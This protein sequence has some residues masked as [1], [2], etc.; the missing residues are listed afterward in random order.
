MSSQ[1]RKAD[2]PV[3]KVSKLNPQCRVKLGRVLVQVVNIT[4]KTRF[5]KFRGR[6]SRNTKKPRG[7]RRCLP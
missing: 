3:L 2:L 6:P 4:E 5:R 1:I 7:P